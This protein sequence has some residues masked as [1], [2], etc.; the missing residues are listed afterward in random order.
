MTFLGISIP[1]MREMSSL[2]GIDDTN[3][4]HSNVFTVPSAYLISA[5]TIFESLTFIPT[6]SAD[7]LICTPLSSQSFAT[8]SHS[9][10]GPYFG[11]KKLSIREVSTSFW[12][13]SFCFFFFESACIIAFFM[14]MPFILCAPQAELISEHF[15]PQTFSV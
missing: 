15:T 4:S 10:P 13:I 5:L 12:Y 14:E 2:I 11:Y 7:L 3:S 8:L 1:F 9:W 6:I